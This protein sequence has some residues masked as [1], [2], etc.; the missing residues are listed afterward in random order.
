MRKD[1]HLFLDAPNGALKGAIGSK[2]WQHGPMTWRPLSMMLS[3]ALVACGRQGATPQSVSAPAP[4]PKAEVHAAHTVAFLGDSLTAGQG[5]PEAQAYPALIQ[6]RLRAEGLD[7]RV[8]NAGISGDTTAG[9]AAR[10]DW[11]YRQPIDVLVV[12]LGANDGL[13]GLPLKE[14]EKNL[15]VIVRRA[16]KEGSKVLLAGMQ[17]PENYGPEYRKAFAALFPKVAKEEGVP[18]LPFLLEGVALDPKLNQADGIHPN[19]EGAKRV[20]E[21]VWGSLHPMLK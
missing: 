8:I 21:T 17:M 19:P 12:A 15:H 18:L 20:A 13:R 5:L 3:L 6:A 11:L 2:P 1:V 14:T 16:K 4:A 7:W 9:G 10:M